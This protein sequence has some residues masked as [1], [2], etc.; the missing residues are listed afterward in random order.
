MRGELKAP[1][2]IAALAI[3]MGVGAARFVNLRAQSPLQTHHEQAPDFPKPGAKVSGTVWLDSSPLTM[4]ALRG[5]VVLVD[6]WEYTCINCIRTFATN[7][8]WYQWYHNDGFEIVGVHAPEF[9]FA[10]NVD[11]VRVAVKR[12]GL[13]Y[14][15]VTDDWFYIW[16]S[17]HNQGWPGRYLIDAKGNI[18]FS[19]IGEG[20]DVAFESAIRKLLVEAHPGLKFP[21]NEKIPPEAPAFGFGCGIP[22]EEMY[23]GPMYG[24]GSLANHEGYKPGTTIDYKL[25]KK[26]ADGRTVIG[27]HWQTDQN[28]MI[29]EGKPQQPGPKAARLE[30]RYHARELYAVINV[31]RGKPSRLFIQQDG[32]WLTAAEKGV[33]A[34]IDS[35]GRSYLDIAEPR[36]YYLVANARFGSHTVTLFPT[37][38]G[39][40]VNSFT[41][42][43][44]CQT[45]FPHL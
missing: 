25:P 43:N 32:H 27:G 22:T 15:I 31:V 6:F 44:D 14:P 4:A 37:E 36:M 29:Y 33:D 1:V 40:T 2:L 16:K 8:R 19:R 45:D 28:G 21:A 30:M 23:V 41:F 5:K 38:T 17:Y 42:G 3:T 35:Q 20:G 24:R 34:R 7:K 39:L 11:N 26:V 18:R 9:D 13:P 12:F 10:Y